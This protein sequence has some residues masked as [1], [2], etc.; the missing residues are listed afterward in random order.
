MAKV[1]FDME[2]LEEVTKEAALHATGPKE[3]DLD[4]VLPKG[5][6][7][8]NGIKVKDIMIKNISVD[9]YDILH[10]NGHNFGSYAKIAVQEKMKADGLI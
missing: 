3:V 9:L 5:V 8:K 6:R 7:I 10:D 4:E 1:K 2:A